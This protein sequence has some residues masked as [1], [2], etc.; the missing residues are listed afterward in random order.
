MSAPLW[1]SPATTVEHTV[2]LTRK[3]IGAYQVIEIG[4][5]PSANLITWPP[6]P[7]IIRNTLL[8]RKYRTP[9]EIAVASSPAISHGLNRHHPFQAVAIWWR[10]I[11]VHRLPSERRLPA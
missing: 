2:R 3:P 9:P 1:T 11:T 4:R 5:I 6:S 8:L 10:M 7:P